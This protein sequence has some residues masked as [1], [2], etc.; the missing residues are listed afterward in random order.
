M[1]SIVYHDDLKEIQADP[2]LMALVGEGGAS[3]PFDRLA[4]WR[5][6][7]EEAGLTPLIAVARDGDARALLPLARHGQ[8]LG[9][10][11][12]WYSFRLAPLATRGADRPALFTALAAGLARL[13]PHIVLEPLPD[14]NG[15]ASLLEAAFRQAG[16]AVF[17]EVCDENHVLPVNG[18]SYAEYLAAR[19]GPL[20]TTL[21]RRAGKVAVGIETTFN[22]ESWAAYETVYAQSWKPDEGQPALLRRFAEQEGA[23][24]RLR[25]GI[26]RDPAD[27]TSL[28]AQFWTVEGGTAFIHKLAHTEAS[29]PLSPGT[30]L[31]AALFAQVI[32]QDH[33]SLVDFGTGND[34]YKRDWM[35]AIR[36]R[37]RLELLRPGHPGCWPRLARI[38]AKRLV[39]RGLR[40]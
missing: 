13:A 37:Y 12:N 32:D 11:V 10:L 18:R 9:G 22:A 31:S 28:A 29:K 24:G 25:L 35:E 17:R 5:L 23:A 4:W 16:W 14:D 33:V 2:A 20:R 36:P 7:A 21:K 40:A 39:S 19:P 26:A 34:G 8:R 3:A 1:V 30:T 27:G 38:V 15:E 6:L